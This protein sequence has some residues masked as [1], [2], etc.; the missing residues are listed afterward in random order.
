MRQLG[1]KSWLERGSVVGL[2]VGK[3][4]LAGEV[5]VVNKEKVWYAYPENVI[6]HRPGVGQG[7][8]MGFPLEQRWCD[9]GRG[10]VRR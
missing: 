3:W 10:G 4:A 7:Y 5:G 9:E 8:D 2:E 1:R 6:V